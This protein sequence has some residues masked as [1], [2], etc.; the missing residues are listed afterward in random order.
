MELNK[1]AVQDLI[2]LLKLSTCMSKVVILV[3]GIFVFTR[4]I[5]PFDIL[6]VSIGIPPHFISSYKYPINWAMYTECETAN[7]FRQF[8]V[9][10]GFS[11]E[12]MSTKRITLFLRSSRVSPPGGVYV[13]SSDL[14]TPAWFAAS[15][16]ILDDFPSIIPKFL[17]R[18]T[19]SSVIP[20]PHILSKFVF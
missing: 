3:F 13:A 1:V 16:Y 15:T 9:V 2:V 7:I 17:S 6:I 20:L 18:S 14:V 10:N 12:I 8:L 5:I 4:S 11:S 19:G